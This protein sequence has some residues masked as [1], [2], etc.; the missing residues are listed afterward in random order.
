VGFRATRVLRQTR[1]PTLISDVCGARIS[2]RLVSTALLRAQPCNV[3]LAT[4]LPQRCVQL[5]RDVLPSMW[6]AIFIRRSG[7]QQPDGSVH[8]FDDLPPAYAD[9][10]DRDAAGSCCRRLT[11]LMN[12]NR[13]PHRF[14]KTLNDG[15]A[16]HEGRRADALHPV[17]VAFHQ[18]WRP[19]TG[20][21]LAEPQAP[22]IGNSSDEY[23]WRVFV[24]LNWPVVQ[25]AALSQATLGCSL[26]QSGIW[27]S[28]NDIFTPDDRSR[29]GARTHSRERRL[30]RSTLPVSRHSPREIYRICSGCKR[31]N[32]P[33]EDPLA[34]ATRLTEST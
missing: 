30:C 32:G 21:S 3:A 34:S 8:K 24:A 25:Y 20:S 4:L 26:R 12:R 16:H 5:L 22:S 29:P 19:W 23:A 33:G 2:R 14:L 11:A 13:R 15:T 27:S 10:I 7:T 17:V 6:S 31:E 1:S 18:S 9:N 28:A